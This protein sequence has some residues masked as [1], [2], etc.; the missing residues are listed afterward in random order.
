VNSEP[1]PPQT[2][3]ITSFNNP[4]VPANARPVSDRRYAWR[5]R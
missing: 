4:A 2:T 1:N 3:V 5:Y